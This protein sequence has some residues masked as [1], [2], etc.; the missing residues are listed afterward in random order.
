[1]SQKSTKVRG[2]WILVDKINEEHK[3]KGGLLL[4]E[5]DVKEAGTEKATV[6]DV[7]PA[8]TGAIKIGDIAIYES[9]LA[10]SVEIDGEIFRVVPEQYIILV[11]R[12]L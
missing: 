6:I 10:N 8:S 9:N 4:S 7:G 1:M 2:Q 5:S 12:D 11:Q 3:S